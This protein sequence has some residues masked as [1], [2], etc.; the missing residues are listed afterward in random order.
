MGHTGISQRQAAAWIAVVFAIA[1][2]YELAVRTDMSETLALWSRRH[3]SLELDEL[4]LATVVASVGLGWLAATCSR[5]LTRALATSQKREGALRVS[6]ERFRFLTESIREAF[7]VDD[8]DTGEL[9]VSPAGAKIWGR[10]AEARDTSA[11]TW[12]E[13][14]HSDDV[15]GIR[16]RYAETRRG[17][18][19]A[20][21]FRIVRPDGSERWIRSRAFPI[22]DNNGE[23]RRIAGVA[24]DVTSQKHAEHALQE[25]HRAL[26]ARAA[27]RTR[28]LAQTVRELHEEEARR[29]EAERSLRLPMFAVEHSPYAVAWTDLDGRVVYV[30][31]QACRLLGYSR[32]EL[33]GMSIFDINPNATPEMFRSIED[34]MLQPEGGTVELHYESRD[35][36]VLPI[37][38]AAYFLDFEGERLA[39]SFVQDISDRTAALHALRTSEERFRL[40]TLATSDAIYDWDLHADTIWTSERHDALLGRPGKRVAAWVLE[41]IHPDDRERAVGTLAAALRNGESSWSAEYRMRLTS[42]RYHRFVSRASLVRDDAGRPIRMIGALNDV[43]EARRAR[44]S[45]KQADRLAFL[46]TLGAGLAHEL[47]SPLGSIRMAAEHAMKLEGRPDADALRHECL[48]DIVTGVA[49]SAQIAQNVLRFAR[50]EPTE[51]WASD[52]NRVVRSA[53]ECFRSAAHASNA[54]V[55]LDLARDLPRIALSPIC[56]EQGL[57]N[58]LQNAIE[59]GGPATRVRVRTRRADDEVRIEVNDDG[60]G[61]A[62]EV[63]ERLLEPFFT[64]RGN[65]GGT[66]LGLS[67]VEIIAADHGGRIDFESTRGEGTTVSL[68]LPVEL[69]PPRSAELQH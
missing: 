19:H 63:R 25:A 44:E 36:R 53:V 62:G 13:S 56:I 42:G 10:P 3:E 43:T 55:E 59:A 18:P 40:A 46:A 2:T 11:Q 65:A 1:A 26:E 22:F 61:I 38:V 21:E 4:T 49:R 5:L 47:N 20:L 68:C 8:L 41:R 6:E 12:L 23:V 31:Q 58:L 16:A 48:E 30:N 9:Y 54:N 33:V 32:G 17:E 39:C 34:A 67:L 37:E 27:K 15:P 14:I 66:G 60:P 7:W 24:E 69:G 50:H 28:E 35:G 52:P 64:T 29:R 45:A 57:V 51:K